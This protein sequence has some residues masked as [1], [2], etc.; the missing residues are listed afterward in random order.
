MM[1]DG[2]NLVKI[3]IQVD[4]FMKVSKDKYFVVLEDRSSVKCCLYH[5]IKYHDIKKSGRIRE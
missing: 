2:I 4:H 1:V 3:K 5:P